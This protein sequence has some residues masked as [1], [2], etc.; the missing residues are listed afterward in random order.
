VDGALAYIEAMTGFESSM[1][2]AENGTVPANVAAFAAV[3]P[4][5]EIDARRLAITR[6]TIATGMITYPPLERFPAVEDAG[7]Q[8]INDALRG[9]ADPADVPAR[10][11]A[12]AA[13]VLA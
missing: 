11:Q 9:R 13:A 5:D 3:E 1:V 10:I 8:A 12:A 7:W 4:E 2:D 6:D